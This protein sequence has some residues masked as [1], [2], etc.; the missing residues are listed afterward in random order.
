M[1]DVS[2]RTTMLRAVGLTRDDVRQRI[3]EGQT[4]RVERFTT[5]TTA[6]ILQNN[7]L[8]LFVGILTTTVVA[9][10]VIDAYNDAVFLGA[11]TVAN[12]LAGIIGEFRAK[13]ALDQ[14]AILA[15]RK[16]TVVRESREEEIPS[17]DLVKDDLIVVRRGDA[18]MADGVL[19]ASS[20]VFLDESLLTGEADLVAKREGDRV[21]SGSY[22]VR[23]PVGTWQQAWAPFAGNSSRCW[24][25]PSLDS[26]GPNIYTTANRS[27]A[28]GLRST[29]AAS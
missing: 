13:W 1:T 5:R 25:T 10:L 3:A 23:G 24:S 7:I 2:P 29:S 27:F 22:C 20:K 19:T 4:N 18:I 14:L 9:L 26:S 16:I 15:R 8:T 11:V 12:V 28:P 17:D 6:G 21:F